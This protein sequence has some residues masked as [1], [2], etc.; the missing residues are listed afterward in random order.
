MIHTAKDMLDHELTAR[1][2]T[3][4]GWVHSHPGHGLF[5][6]RTDEDTLSA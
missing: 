6:S 5:L 3:I 1:I 4:V 2:G